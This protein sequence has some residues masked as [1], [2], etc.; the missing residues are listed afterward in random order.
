M[1]I[2]FLISTTL[3][4]ATTARSALRQVRIYLAARKES[5][6]LRRNAAA[7]LGWNYRHPPRG[8][9]RLEDTPRAHR[10]CTRHDP[11]AYK[12]GHLKG[13][14]ATV[15]IREAREAREAWENA[16]R[17]RSDYLSKSDY[18]TLTGHDV[19]PYLD[20]NAVA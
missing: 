14:P 20:A 4:T 16:Y 15:Y 8:K 17:T 6:T 10:R 13:I 19:E 11:C 1:L 18:H 9:H 3:L 7:V 2:P 5:Q 12:V